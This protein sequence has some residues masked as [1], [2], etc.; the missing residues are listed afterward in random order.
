MKI[1]GMQVNFCSI[2]SSETYVVALR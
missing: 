1:I 2:S